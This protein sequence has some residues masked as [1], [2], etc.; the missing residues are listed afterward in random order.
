MLVYWIYIKVVCTECG[1]YKTL[2]LCA[3]DMFIA[4]NNLLKRYLY[5]ISYERSIIEGR[6]YIRYIKLYAINSL[7][8]Q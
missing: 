6:I 8:F 2:E 7:F 1:P 3:N 4:V 5:W